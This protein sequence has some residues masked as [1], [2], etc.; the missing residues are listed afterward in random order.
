MA[1]EL[2]AIENNQVV[3]LIDIECEIQ[4]GTICSKKKNLGGMVW[5]IAVHPDFRR[6]GIA[7]QLL[8]EAENRVKN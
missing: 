4:T 2:V 3:G 6:T 8:C 5:H 1:V 7:Y